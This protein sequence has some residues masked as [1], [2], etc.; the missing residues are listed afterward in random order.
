MRSFVQTHRKYQQ[1]S[2]VSEE[3]AYDLLQACDAISIGDLIV[4][5]LTGDL[6]FT[7]LSNQ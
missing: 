1:D 4:P 3:I 6:P 5:E 7:T 2:V